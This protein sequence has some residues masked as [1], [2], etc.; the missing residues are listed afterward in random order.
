M[1]STIGVDC[2][3]QIAHPEVNDGEPYG[4]IVEPQD[5]ERGPVVRV[6]WEKYTNP[7]GTLTEVRHLWVTVMIADELLNPDGTLHRESA[8]EMYARLI[9]LLTR[10]DR[11]SLVTRLGAITGLKS[12]GHVMEQSIYPGFMR[13]VCQLSSHSTAFQP[14]DYGYYL[15]SYWVDAATYAGIMNWGNSYWRS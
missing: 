1:T 12:S 6:H 15:Q 11:L 9:E 10:P 3:I 13:V 7:N 14:V 2:D 8:A 4:F 5:R